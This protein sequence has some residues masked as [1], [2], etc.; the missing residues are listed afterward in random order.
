M[1]NCLQTC[2]VHRR[3]Q[4][5]T[6]EIEQEERESRWSEKTVS[7]EAGD[8][9]NDLVREKK[10]GMRI[11]IVLTKEE[12]E[13]LMIQLENNTQGEHGEGQRSTLEDV[14]DE[15]ERGRRRNCTVGGG[16]GGGGWKPSLE[17]IVECPE[18]PEC[19]TR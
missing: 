3:Q 12:L 4:Q 14:L 17:S 8:D 13:W 11:K 1:G 18:V 6:K 15:I 16:G 10:S 9:N 7:P 19:I 5:E 2:G